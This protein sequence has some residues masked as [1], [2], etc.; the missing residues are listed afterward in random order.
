V[1]TAFVLLGLL[2][3]GPRHG[4]ELK[5]E[6]DARLP[7]ARPLAFGQVYATIGRLIRDGLIDEAGQD[8]GAGPERMS[9]ALTDEGRE[10]LAA[11]L[12][13]VEEPAPYVQS[14]LLTKVIVALFGSDDAKA[15]RAYLAAQRRAHVDRMRE[16]TRERSDP[17]ASIAD[18]AA[19][20]YAIQHLDADVRWMQTTLDRVD[21][22]HR[23]VARS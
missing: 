9:Y 18:V 17:Q 23:E 1:S 7:R 21:A 3:R 20:D 4:Y 6:H 11:W 2:A 13:S 12:A 8:K 19:A 22:L 14:T 15:A 10:K 5:R 16:L